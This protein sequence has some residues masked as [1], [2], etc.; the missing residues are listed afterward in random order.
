[1][2]LLRPRETK[3]LTQVCAAG[4]RWS[5]AA[6]PGSVAPRSV[7]PTPVTPAIY[8]LMLD[9][10]LLLIIG[11]IPPLQSTTCVIPGKSPTLSELWLPNQITGMMIFL[12]GGF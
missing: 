12:M 11:Q 4:K 10:L 8:F 9:K 3:E 1:M 6:Q 2:R 5:W 7:P